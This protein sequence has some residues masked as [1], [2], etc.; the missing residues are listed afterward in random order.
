MIHGI[1]TDILHIN[2][3]EPSVR[4]EDSPFVRKVY[5]VKETELIQSRPVPL[6]CYATRF[7]G[8]EAV[9]KSL[10]VD[11][12]AVRLNEIEILETEYN[13]PVVILHGRAASL[14]E[15]FGIDRIHI[16]LSYDTDYITAFA[17]A[18]CGKQV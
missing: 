12:D 9:F 3:I 4:D 14:A 6:Y 15:K 13:Q 11:G 18:E 17:V 5:T 8:K 7:A 10:G 16:S 1:G 2:T